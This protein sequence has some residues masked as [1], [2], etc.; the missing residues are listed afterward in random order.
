VSVTG[1][2]RLRSATPSTI[3]TALRELDG[4]NSDFLTAVLDTI[5]ASERPDPWG[6]YIAHDDDGVV[7]GACCFKAAP[8]DR[9]VEIAYAVLPTREGQGWAKRMVRDLTAIA[10]ATKGTDR[11]MAHTLREESASTGVLRRCA[12]TF[13]GD[14]IDLED[15]PVWRWKLNLRQ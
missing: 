7:V 4:A 5:T 3:Q 8:H 12:F 11:I 1:E 13:D 14:A 10:R 15:G 2:A 9:A 6:A